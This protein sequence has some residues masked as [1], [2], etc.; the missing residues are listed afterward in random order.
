MLPYVRRADP[1]AIIYER[2]VVTPEYAE[3]RP[4][5][6]APFRNVPVPD[7]EPQEVAT[8]SDP[9]LP[10]ADVPEKRVADRI[11]RGRNKRHHS[12]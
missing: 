5:V 2:K 6:A 7:E 11:G 9:V 3:V 8:A 4:E 1:P 10:S 12:R